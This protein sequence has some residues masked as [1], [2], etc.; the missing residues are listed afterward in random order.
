[1]GAGDDEKKEVYSRLE[2]E[3]KKLEGS[4]AR[5]VEQ[6]YG[7]LYSECINFC[8]NFIF[9]YFETRTVQLQVFLLLKGIFCLIFRNMF[10]FPQAWQYLLKIC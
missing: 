10:C 9:D 7:S 2:E 8:I 4:P 6:F 1:M 5:S 3:V